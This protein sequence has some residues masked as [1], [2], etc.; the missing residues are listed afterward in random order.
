M[1][2]ILNGVTGKPSLA[3]AEQ[4]KKLFE[5]MVEDLSAIVEK[6]KV[7]VPPLEY[8]YSSRVSET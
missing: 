5:W 4:G 7:E 1:A 2:E 8:S 6:G 3:N